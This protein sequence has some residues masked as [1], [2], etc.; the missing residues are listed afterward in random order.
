ME[1]NTE[2]DNDIIYSMFD[3]LNNENKFLM[4]CYLLISKRYHIL[5]LIIK[6]TR[7]DESIYSKIY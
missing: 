6:S 2:F 3:C 1:K 4:F 5:L 7:Y